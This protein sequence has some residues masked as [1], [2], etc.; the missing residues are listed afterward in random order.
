MTLYRARQWGT[1]DWTKISITASSEED[2]AGLESTI[3]SIIGSALETSP[4]HV[5]FLNDDGEWEDL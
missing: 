2:E 5:Q 4:L 3:A 1:A